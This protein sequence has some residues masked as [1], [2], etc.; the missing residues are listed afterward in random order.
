MT[1]IYMEDAPFGPLM[2]AASEKGLAYLSACTRGEYERFKREHPAPESGRAAEILEEARR[3]V[4]EYYAGRRRAFDL[5][6]DLSG[7]TPF[8]ESVLRACASIPFG[9][10][11]TYG[12]LAARAGHPGAA[13]AAG[14]AMA[15]NPIGL[16]IPCHRVV[17]C[18]RG[19]HGF[20]APGGLEAKAALLRHEGV[21][22][23]NGKAA[24]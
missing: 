10:T 14:G 19:L 23:V 24:A 18:D 9:Q 5:P 6:L 7:Q 8:R 11:V 21:R 2:L 22:V 16:V 20:S 12:E 13:R 1:C 17:G 3:Q 4:A 15:H